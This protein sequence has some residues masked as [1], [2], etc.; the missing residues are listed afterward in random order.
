MYKIQIVWK[1]LTCITFLH[2]RMFWPI[3]QYGTWNMPTK[4]DFPLTF[5]GQIMHNNCRKQRKRI[6]SEDGAEY[7][8]TLP[9]WQPWYPNNK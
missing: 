2:M 6:G 7:N 3:I 9:W 5:G 4:E 8:K 1:Y